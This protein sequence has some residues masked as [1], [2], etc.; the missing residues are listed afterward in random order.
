VINETVKMHR[1]IGVTAAD[2][3]DAMGA[4]ARHVQESDFAR[5]G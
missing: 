4:E 3:P 2:P 1:Y 5:I